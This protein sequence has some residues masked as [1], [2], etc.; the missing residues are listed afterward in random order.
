MKKIG[1]IGMNNL[2]KIAALQAMILASDTESQTNS[3]FVNFK[4]MPLPYS[5]GLERLTAYSTG[6]SGYRKKVKSNKQ[7]KARKAAKRA[8]QARKRSRK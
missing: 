3:G 6:H 5:S 2:G 4:S 1:H 8:K 7:Q